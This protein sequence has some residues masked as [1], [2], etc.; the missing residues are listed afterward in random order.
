VTLYVSDPLYGKGKFPF[1]AGE[2][3]VLL[4]PPS[5]ESSIRNLRHKNK[6]TQQHRKVTDPSAAGQGDFKP[7]TSEK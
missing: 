2:S 6:R 4:A 5:L 1:A 3:S 7:S